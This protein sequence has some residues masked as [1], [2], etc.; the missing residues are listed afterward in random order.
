[1]SEERTILNVINPQWANNEQTMIN[2]MVEF[3]ETPELGLH[4]FSA[5]INSSTP[6]G[7]E[8]WN[9]VTAGEFG[10]IAEYVE[11]P[12]LPPE[13]LTRR[14][15]R[16]GLLAGGILSSD[17]EAAIAD[18]PNPTDKAVAEIE[19]QDATQ[20]ERNHPLLEMV[21]QMLGLST[22]QIDAMWEHALTL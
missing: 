2:V 15:L 3:E 14:Q 13:P 18:I 16:L 4:P 10:E 21:G 9:R 6:Y 12:P 22:E 1:M 5:M 20:Y 7:Q 17:V 8:V 19:W 11:P